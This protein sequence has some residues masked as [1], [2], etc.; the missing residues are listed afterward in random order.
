MPGPCA[1]YISSDISATDCCVV[2]QLLTPSQSAIRKHLPI[3]IKLL[4][5]QI[6]MD[7][8]HISREFFKYFYNRILVDHLCGT[9]KLMVSKWF[10]DE[11]AV[12]RKLLVWL[13]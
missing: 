10:W 8:S 13:S 7:G 2:H 4:Y 12:K 3:H 1:V 5:F 11:A 6:E 9:Q